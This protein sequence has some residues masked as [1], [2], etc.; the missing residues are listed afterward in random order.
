MKTSRRNLLLASLG[1]A[2]LALLGRFGVRSA[3]AGPKPTGPTKLLCIWLDGGC[4]WEHIFS[5]LT[6][7]G[8]D[9][10]I[11][12]P[13]GG[14]HPF[15]YSKGQVRNFD[16]SAADLADPGSKRKLRGPVFWNDANPADTT[17]SNPLS[18]DTQTFR[19]IAAVAATGDASKYEAPE[20]ANTHWSNWPD[21]GLL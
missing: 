19:Q 16:G 20:P 17:G 18:G 8:I 1:A 15:G 11:V 21:G 2:Q 10:F 12:A 14:N 5:P 13:E 6:A 3:F 9:K 7:S 4:N